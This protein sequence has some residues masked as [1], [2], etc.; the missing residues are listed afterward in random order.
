[1]F[2]IPHQI[3]NCV[4]QQKKRCKK[5]AKKITIFY[6]YLT[7]RIFVTYGEKKF[8][9]CYHRMKYY[10]IQFRTFL[11]IKQKHKYVNIF[12]YAF[13]IIAGVI[14]VLVFVLSTFLYFFLFFLNILYM[15]WVNP[16]TYTLQLAVKQS[17]NF[18]IIFFL[19]N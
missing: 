10:L 8:F 1:M 2:F 12:A 7:K 13:I 9:F 3:L 4:R 17:Y 19:H 16:W 18:D 14:T 15:L 5:G 6:N 11:F